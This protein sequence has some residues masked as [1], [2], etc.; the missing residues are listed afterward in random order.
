MNNSTLSHIGTQIQNAL[1]SL[2]WIRDLQ[3]MDGPLL[4]I[5]RDPKSG[6]HY[7]FHWVDCD[8]EKN[9]WLVCEIAEEALV[10][11][12]EGLADLRESLTGS[13]LLF[14]VDFDSD[15][16]YSTTYLVPNITELPNEYL[17]ETGIKIDFSLIPKN[18]SDS[19]IYS[20]LLNHNDEFD[21]NTHREIPKLFKEL[22]S[23][24]FAQKSNEKHL[25]SIRP[26][27]GG[28]S[29][30]HLYKELSNWLK[31]QSKFKIHRYSY[32]SPG[33]LQFKVDAEVIE[34]LLKCIYQY[35]ISESFARDYVTEIEHYNRKNELNKDVNYISDEDNAY[36]EPLGRELSEL[37]IFPQWD[38]LKNEGLNAFQSSKIVI[39][40]WKRLGQLISY[41]NEHL[42]QLTRISG[43][44]FT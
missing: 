38:F 13:T 32:A 11:L 28:F 17:P 2:I 21:I 10:R 31:K 4:S 20:I 5:F 41:Q 15:G 43:E 22:Y 33:V 19:N 6:S 39:A 9:R 34:D 3:W 36:L 35:Q 1:K 16:S 44:Q 24:V 27:K 14:L 7:I 42:I 29:S 25:F 30:M 40:Q 12:E 26:Y 37:I 23:V 8:S 18:E